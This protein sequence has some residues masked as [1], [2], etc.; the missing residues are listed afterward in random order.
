MIIELLRDEINY[1]LSHWCGVTL[2]SRQLTLVTL[3]VILVLFNLVIFTEK[4][5]NICQIKVSQKFHVIRYPLGLF[6]DWEIN[7]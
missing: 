3:R 1:S 4:N 2:I 5:R 7:G 6:I